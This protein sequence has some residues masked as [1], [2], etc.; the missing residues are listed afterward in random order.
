MQST[1]CT[2]LN[3]KKLVEISQSFT[4]IIRKKYLFICNLI[5]FKHPFVLVDLSSLLM[6]TD[7]DE[8]SNGAIRTIEYMTMH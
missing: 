4:N 6:H 1:F 3:L 5:Q 7:A 8:E 2:I